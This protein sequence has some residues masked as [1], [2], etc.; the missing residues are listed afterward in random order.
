MFHVCL[1][2]F[3]G[4][5]VCI[6]VLLAL[7]IGCAVTLAPTFLSPTF[8]ACFAL[9]ASLTK[10]FPVFLIINNIK[11]PDYKWNHN[12]TFSCSLFACFV[13]SW[14]GSIL[15][16]LHDLLH[17]LFNQKNMLFLKLKNIHT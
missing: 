11:I 5:D 9:A 17:S 2:V 6:C 7:C 16:L 15:I 12:T 4:S 10:R 3:A 14:P 1:D 13:F 8:F